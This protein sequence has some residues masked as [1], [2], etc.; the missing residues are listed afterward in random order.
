VSSSRLA[1]SI[2]PTMRLGGGD[3]DEESRGQGDDVGSQASEAYPSFISQN[4]RVVS[5]VL[6]IFC[7]LLLRSHAQRDYQRDAE[8]F[9]RSKGRED[10]LEYVMPKS[11]A[12]VKEEAMSQKELL[13]YLAAK[14]KDL[15]ARV[16]ALEGT[17]GRGSSAA[18]APS[19]A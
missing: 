9:L 4:R 7:L 18:T 6:G 8:K 3:S 11:A 17:H 12:E 19:E 1:A 13:A 15:E 2:R 14:S 16:A 5:I 10:A